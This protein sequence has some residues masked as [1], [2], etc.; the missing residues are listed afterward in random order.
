[1]AFLRNWKENT[2]KK[3]L[4]MKHRYLRKK[5]IAL[6]KED[7]CSL[8]GA[9]H[10]HMSQ[11]YGGITKTGKVALTG[12]CCIKQVVKIMMGGVYVDPAWIRNAP[13]CH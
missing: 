10:P 1:M 3:V 9:K 11:F 7:N 8:C 13:T 4:T 2:A 6:A 5:L 12:D